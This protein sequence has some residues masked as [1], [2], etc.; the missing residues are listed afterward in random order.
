MKI[1]PL[2]FLAFLPE[3][4]PLAIGW[5]LLYLAWELGWFGGADALA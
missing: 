5:G 4:L 3:I 2:I 1:S